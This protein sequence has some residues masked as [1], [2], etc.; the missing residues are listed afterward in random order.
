MNNKVSRMGLVREAAECHLLDFIRLVAPHRAL[1][2]IHEELVRWW[3]RDDAGDH[4]LALLPRDHQKSA[5]V[6]Y[7][8]AWTIT[9]DP[10]ATF[11]YI[12]STSG[13]AEKQLYFIK[14][15]LDS[16]IYRRYWP[17]MIHPDEGKRE[18]WSKNE[19]IIDHPARKLEGIRDATI[20]TAGL[21]TGITGLHFTH[22]VLDDVVVKE[23]A[24][25]EEGRNTVR[26]QYSLL[27]SIESTG[28][29]KDST[30][31]QEWVVG[32]R[33]DPRDLYNDLVEM[34]YEI[35]DD[36]SEIID[37]KP[38]YEVYQKEVEDRGDGSGE[39]LWPRQQNTTGRWFGFDRN[40]LAKKRAKYLDKTQFRA[41]YYNNPNDPDNAFIDRSRFQYYDK[42]YIE[43]QGG[44]WYYKGNKLNVVAA[45]DFAF[46][47]RKTADYTAIVVLGADSDNNLYILDIDR[48]KTEGRISE[49]YKHIF[50]LHAK[51]GFRKLR[52]EVTVAQKAIVEELRTT[53]IPQ[54]G[55]AL[56]IDEYRPNRNEGNKEERI[57]ALLE[58]RY[59]NG[60]VY[61]YKGG[62]CQVL[63]DELTSNHP[64]HD[65]IKD[66]LAA[67][68][69]VIIPPTN[70]RNKA[71]KTNIIPI[72]SRFGG[73]A[74][75]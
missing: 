24:Y 58:P 62:Y 46:S 5:L 23:N 12:S 31:A 56:F 72:H 25:S 74:A 71:Y 65:D 45:I 33:Y 14:Q 63:E 54:H 57:A 28:T 40:I 52:A 13:L 17:D 18:A 30:G 48:F 66:C 61:H 44:S 32:T 15:I 47:I 50:E 6:A 69:D 36:D 42:K 49:Y 41:Q 55:L 53:Y 43:E 3:T 19:I 70:R 27:S 59:M 60:M 10:T 20:K 75:A 4:Q 68:V 11:L 38:V 7:R 37:M 21:T 73:V 29:E 51:W 1:G 39:F 35:Y 22:A 67:A 16:K 8:V 64:A 2:S 9:K 26:G 34:E